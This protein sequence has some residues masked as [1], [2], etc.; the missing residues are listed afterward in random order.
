MTFR[1]RVFLGS[2]VSAVVPLA[3]SGWMLGR[4]GVARLEEQARLRV[5]DRV[6]EVGETITAL[7]S[8]LQR[9]L[10]GIVERMEGD[11]P[12]RLA[13]T[14]LS[15]RQ[16]PELT[17]WAARTQG[18]AGLSMLQLQDS[19]GTILS[20]G[21]FRSDFG[22]QDPS[23][24]AALA[25]ASGRAALAEVVG[26]Q[27]RD[28]MLVASRSLRLGRVPLTLIGGVPFAEARFSGRTGALTVRLM[29]S[30]ETP[31]ESGPTAALSFALPR[32]AVDEAGRSRL[33]SVHVQVAHSLEDVDRLRRRA[34]IGLV[35]GVG[36]AALLATVVSRLL[37]AR[38]TAPLEDL[39]RRSGAV[40][41]DAPMRRFDSGRADEVGRLARVL[42]RMLDR[43]SESAA[44][45][46][47]AER[48]A[49]LGDLARQVNHDVKNAVAPLRNVMRHLDQMDSADAH[50]LGTVFR[51]RRGTLAA[52]V[53]YLGELADRYGRLAA[54]RTRRLFAVAEVLERVGRTHA[55]D[56]RLEV[57]TVDPALQ[58]RGDPLALRRVLE[59]LTSN[60]LDAVTPGDGRVALGAGLDSDEAGPDRVVL[61]VEDN[62]AGMDAAEVRRA[63]EDFYTSKP[64][65]S[66][67][68]LSIVRR[69]VADLEGTM[70]VTSQP[71]QGTRVTLTF[72]RAH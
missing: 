22:R 67:L 72:P 54:P 8:D 2:L 33:D 29:E 21:H 4:E 37:A 16:A 34:V 31:G 46:R 70:E 44:R 65:G 3:V 11:D 62:G 49:A 27:G 25:S 26:S 9:R 60:A 66:G 35:L 50:A 63:Q 17:D 28:S 14:R 43:L 7:E 71:G 1:T 15:S 23:F 45:L 6:V 32:V 19:S 58:L 38:V 10:D 51:E 40:D 12:L 24:A 39:A 68:G 5:Q 64:R 61:T 55:A 36:L 20:S 57:G 53:D 56:P 48:E 41:L 42:D 13:V 30:P 47:K 18:L 69:L 52:G 59:N